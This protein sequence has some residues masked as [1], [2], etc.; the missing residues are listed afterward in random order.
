MTLVKTAPVLTAQ[1]HTH[2]LEHGFVVIKGV[3]SP[4]TIAAAVETLEAGTYSGKVGDA[5][6]RPVRAEAVA[7]C[8]TDRV[9][10]AI[11]E[12]FGE[13]YPFDR[14]RDGVDMPRPL[15]QGA[16]WPIPVA[17]I[18][19]DYPTIMPNGWALGMFL[20]LTP[21]RSHGGAFIVFPGS[22][23]RYQQILSASPDKIFGVVATAEAAGEYQELLAEPGD[24]LLFHHLAGHTGSE[25]I[26]DPLTRHALLGRWHPRKRIDPAGKSIS[27]MS[28]IEKANSL[29]HQRRAF[30]G[31]FDAPACNTSAEAQRILSEGISRPGGIRA[32]SL[33]HVDGTS[34]LLCVDGAA[35]NVIQHAVS[36][37]L[38]NW[39]FGQALPA[40]DAPITSFSLYQR[41]KDILLFASVGGK[42]RILASRDFDTWEEVATVLSAEHGAGHFNT[43]FGSA[44]A[45]G[46]VLFYISPATKSQVRCCWAGEWSTIGA[47][48]GQESVVIET[49]D[50]H[51]ITGV[52]IKPTL[53]EVQFAVVLDIAEEGIVETHPFYSLSSDSASYPS[54]LRPLAYTTWNAPRAIQVYRRARNYWLITYIRVQ[55]DQ[56]RWFWG[57]IDWEQETPAIEEITDTTQWSRAF[58][59]VGLR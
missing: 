30:E 28:T 15:R 18:D 34:H 20:F 2:F 50:G 16:A 44:I 33:I 25:N 53:G 37:D 17:H 31:V 7:E 45:R 58:D 6:Y 46:N 24:L 12:L 55:G 19:D 13:E 57:I 22:Y 40:F 5:N 38:L 10:N 14:I 21:V 36:G 49:A 54:A 29:R 9:H 42:I 51:K 43:N 47:V 8:I 52:C 39:K 59:I 56:E 27:D 23:R 26:A 41:G 1:D 11:G 3:V 32:Q 35:R 48:K 4:E